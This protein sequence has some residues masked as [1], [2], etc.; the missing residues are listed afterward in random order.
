MY[1]S[2]ERN[3]AKRNGVS[4]Q[5][6]INTKFQSPLRGWGDN[7]RR[8]KQKKALECCGLCRRPRT[9]RLQNVKQHVNNQPLTPLWPGRVATPRQ[10][11]TNCGRPEL[12][13]FGE[14][15]VVGVSKGEGR[16]INA[17]QP[18]S[19]LP[20]LTIYAQRR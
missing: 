14:K 17:F 9:G 3:E 12:Q 13:H 1:D 7:I 6:N 5:N 2:T 8:V 19:V 4:R 18:F 16:T 10:R 20:C 11:N 15:R